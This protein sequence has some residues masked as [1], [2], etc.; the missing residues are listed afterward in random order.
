M[1]TPILAR[2]FEQGADIAVHS[3]TK[4]IGGHG[5]SIGGIVVDSG[6]LRL[7]GERRAL[8]R[9]DEAGPLLPRRRLGRRARAGRV[10]RPRPHGAAAQ[11][12]RGDLAVQ[13]VDVPRRG[14]RRC[15]CGSSG[16]RRTPSPSRGTS[17]S[18][19]PSAGSTTRASTRARTRRS[20]TASSRAA[21][22]ASSRSASPA[23]ARPGKAFIESLELFSHL[24][25]IGDA[26]SLAIHNASTTHSQ[27]NDDELAVVRRDPGHGAAVGRDREHRRHPRGPRPG[28]REGRGPR[29]GLSGAV[30]GSVGYVETQRVVLFTEDDP[31]VLESGETLAPVEVAYETYGTLAAGRLERGLRLPRPDRRRARCGSPR[32]RGAPRL[33]G[34]A[35]RP[36]QAARHRPP[37]RDLPEPARRLPGHD[38]AVVDRP[39]DGQALRAAL[40]PLHRR[41][42]RHRAP[43][44][45][46]PPRDRA[47][48]RRDRRLA[49]RHA[50][51]AVGARPP[52]RDRERRSSSAPR[53]ASAPRTS[54]SR[55]WRARR[56]STTS[57]SRAATTTT[58]GETPAGRARGGADDGAHHLRLRGEPAPQVRAR[59]DRRQPRPS[60]STSRSRATSSTR[61]RASSS[62]STPTRTST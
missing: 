28:A 56:S 4:Y 15:R 38:R 7:D 24:A 52:R 57:T 60:T 51:A 27:L 40:P 12:R 11:P 50:G 41:R 13:R 55:R 10:H 9:A 36:R 59:P 21:T 20:P 45:A 42:P 62:A 58:T 33:V 30:A 16:T 1:P 23:A 48:A 34:H 19:T 29:R 46:R 35:D 14:S 18:T 32:R 6:Q 54:R 22:A 3:A 17:S 8:P 44:P 26:K 47:A 2:V 39:G 5:T 31:L 25:N 43:A 49:R 61:A 37:V 53:P